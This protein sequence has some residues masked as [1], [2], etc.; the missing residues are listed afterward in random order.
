MIQ[1]SKL[2]PR[3]Q[4]KVCH[5]RQDPTFLTYVGV[6]SLCGYRKAPWCCLVDRGCRSNLFV[7]DDYSVAWD[8]DMSGQ[9]LTV[10]VLF[11]L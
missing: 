1:D 8:V 3:H 6:E 4:T 11:V 9:W 2:L 5:H 7:D 10:V